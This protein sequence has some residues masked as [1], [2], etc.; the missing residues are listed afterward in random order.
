MNAEERK[1]RAEEIV[2]KLTAEEKAALCS[3]KDFWN[4]V[5]YP[6]KGLPEIRVSDGPNGLRKTHAVETGENESIPATC[7]PTSATTACSFDPSLMKDIGTAIGEECRQENISVLLGPGVNIKRNP[8]GGRNFEYFSEDPYAAGEMACGFIDGVQSQKVGTSLKHF[9]CNSQEKGRLVT[10]SVVDDRALREIYLPAFE[11][12]VSRTQ[13]WTVMASYNRLWGVYNSEN[14]KLLTDILRKEFGFKGLVVSDWGAVSDRAAGVKAGCDLEM[15]YSGPENAEDVLKALK[16]GSLSEEELDRTAV[17]IAELILKAQE[18]E[19]LVYDKKAHHE[20]ARRAAAESCVLLKNEGGLLPGRA[21]QK[22]AV[23]GAMARK[24]RYQGAGSSH[25]VPNL[26]D[27][28]YDELIRHGVS[29]DYAPGYDLNC[30]EPD[31][32]LIREACAAAKGKDIVYLFAG[33]PDAYESE[34]FDREDLFMPSCMTELIRQV[35]EVNPNLAVILMGGSVIDTSWKTSA[36]SILA[37]YL[38]G[39]AGGEAIADVLLGEVNP[40][41]KLAETWPLKLED[42]PSFAYFPGYPKS[43]EYRESIFVGYRYYDTAKAEVSFPFGH[44][45]SYTSFE[46]TDLKISRETFDG[47]GCTEVSCRVKNTGNAAGAEVVQA[48]ISKKDPQLFRAEQE[49]KGFA[50]IRLEPGEEKEVRFSF[51][52][53]DFSIWNVRTG[54]WYIEGGTYEIRIGSSSRDIRLKTEI[55]AAG[56]PG[57]EPDYRESAPCYYDLDQKTFDISIPEFYAVLG[58]KLTRRTRKPGTPYTMNSTLMDL[59]ERK[60]GQAV[61][62]IGKNVAMKK[63]GADAASQVMMESMMDDMPFRFL[64][65]M[66]H[67][68]LPRWKLEAFLEM[69][70][71]HY[72]KGFRELAGKGKED[73]EQD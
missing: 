11:K 32:T 21:Q 56:D 70:N 64:G 36:R 54:G 52:A 44:G 43:V 18:R 17:R 4:L 8:L 23:I 71:S 53:R 51:G 20:I 16:N 6:E 37:A 29:F 34:G 33:L 5:S 15:P 63:F 42:N 26:L 14:K 73:H 1:E 58:R 62:G 25:I 55:T 28:P 48:Y 40:S 65:Q 7:F 38:P 35:S 22:T 49:L 10:D 60:L 46:Y 13:P 45:L 59:K 2:R 66:D 30:E 47:S 3:G 61:L 57:E 67:K 24:M 72:I 50:K 41:G 12:A 68:T 69:M 27:C 9:A 19:P 39:E 31:E